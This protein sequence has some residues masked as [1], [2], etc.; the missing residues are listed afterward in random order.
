MGET[1]Q[2]VGKRFPVGKS[3]N[4]FWSVP[5]KLGETGT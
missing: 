2:N 3:V 4:P 1:K 5:S